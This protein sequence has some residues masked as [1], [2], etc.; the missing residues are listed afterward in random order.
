MRP[1]EVIERERR[2]QLAARTDGVRPPASRRRDHG[3]QRP[4]GRAA[5]AAAAPRS[6][7][8]RRRRAPHGRERAPARHRDPHALRLLLRQLEAAGARGRR[9]DV[10]VRGLPR[11]R[12][13]ARAARGAARERDRP[14]RSP[15]PVAA[16]RHRRHRGG[17][18]RRTRAPPA[19]RRRLLGSRGDPRRGVASALGPAARPATRSSDR[20]TRR[21]TP[22]SRCR[23]STW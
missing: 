2:D 10:A 18:R 9:T 14:A 20:S 16:R 12:A 13:Q 7:R 15:A 3:R 21:S 5:R 4:L 19:P 17:H 6:P 23:S 1:A 22:R 8:R 11:P